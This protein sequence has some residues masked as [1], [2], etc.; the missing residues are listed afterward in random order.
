MRYVSARTKDCARSL[1]S[2]V[3]FLRISGDA[4]AEVA[5]PNAGDLVLGAGARSYWPEAETLVQAAKT[6]PLPLEIFYGLS[7]K[8]FG[9]RI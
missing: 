5:R 8:I 3:E 7:P 1:A 9:K 2:G 4:D 6:H